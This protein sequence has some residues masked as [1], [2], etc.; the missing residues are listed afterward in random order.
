MTAKKAN[1]AAL[2]SALIFPGAGLWW[3][4]HY[5]RASIFI[6]STL[7]SLGYIINTLYHSIEPTYSKMLRDA[8]AGLISPDT[9]TL[10][11]MATKLHH[12][13][14][15]NLA[16]HQ[17]QLNAAQFIFIAGWLCSIASSYFVGKKMDLAEKNLKL[18]A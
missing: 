12:E 14:Y 15:Q 10:L 5:G 8:E 2:F 16:T 1:K 9:T 4:K 11:G 6:V 18:N 3:L 13:I 7:G 17:S